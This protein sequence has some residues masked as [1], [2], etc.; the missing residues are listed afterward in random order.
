MIRVIM[1]TLTL[2]HCKALSTNM[3]ARYL[4]FIGF[5]LTG[6]GVIDREA[7]LYMELKYA[8]K[9]LYGMMCHT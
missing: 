8:N 2:P 4:Y 7:E 3:A 5:E 9:K 6:V 1:R